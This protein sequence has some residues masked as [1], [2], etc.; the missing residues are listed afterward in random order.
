MATTNG[1]TVFDVSDPGAIAVVIDRAMSYSHDIAVVGDRGYISSSAGLQV[2]D[3]SDPTLPSLMHTL[4]TP[5]VGASLFRGTVDTPLSAT[6]P[7]TSSRW[8]QILQD[9]VDSDGDRGQSLTVATPAFDIGSVRLTTTEVGDVAWEVTADGGAS[10]EAIAA[11][12]SWKNI[13][14]SGKDLRWRATLAYDGITLPTCSDLTLEWFGAESYCVAG[15]SAS[16]CQAT[17][18]CPAW[19]A[20]ARPRASPWTRPA[21]RAARTAST[22]T[23]RAGAR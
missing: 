20:P 17:S 15:T 2:V 23:E 14:N 19:P 5:S 13:P 9:L 18:R 21:S 8:P 1:M 6:S 16:G 4:A 7:A 22:S 12:G 10:W 3:V 11:D